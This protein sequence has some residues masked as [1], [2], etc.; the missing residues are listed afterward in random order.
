MTNVLLAIDGP[1][2]GKVIVDFVVNHQWTSGTKFKLIH[3]IEPPRGMDAWPEP[4]FD[5]EEFVS[6]KTMLEELAARIEKSLPHAKVSYSV[7]PGFPKE[8]ILATA[9]EWPA[10]M[11]VV[12]SHGRNPMERFLLGSVSLSVL[13]HAPCTTIVVRVS[14]EALMMDEKRQ[15]ASKER[16][17]AKL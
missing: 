9:G 7:C 15:A 11:I 10:H 4:R 5:D 13:M 6:A 14:Q 17:K 12:G 1:L 16:Q 3:A 2:Y 8:E